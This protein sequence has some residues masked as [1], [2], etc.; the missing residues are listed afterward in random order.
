MDWNEME[1]VGVYFVQY[2][3]PVVALLFSI[4][5]LVCAAKS[6]R[7]QDRVSALE[8]KLAHAETGEKERKTGDADRANLEARIIHV[9]DEEYAIKIRN[10]DGKSVLNVDFHVPPQDPKSLKRDSAVDGQY[11]SI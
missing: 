11:V 9:S 6:R 4:V 3:L 1:I 7:L 10:A 8:E 2:G 5:A